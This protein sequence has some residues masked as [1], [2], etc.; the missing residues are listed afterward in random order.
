MNCLVLHSILN[1]ISIICAD[2]TWGSPFFRPLLF[3]MRHRSLQLPRPDPLGVVLT[4]SFGV[5]AEAVLAA[6]HIQ[7]NDATFTRLPAGVARLVS[8]RSVL[9]VGALWVW[10]CVGFL[11][12][13]VCVG[14]MFGFGSGRRCLG[15]VCV[16]VL[17][18]LVVCFS[19][20]LLWFG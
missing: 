14:G 13:L 8:V 9:V 16:C 1:L 4:A 12:R 5:V 17:L 19:C 7:N 15:V 2:L 11:V 10:G 6:V 18:F 3:S 20:V